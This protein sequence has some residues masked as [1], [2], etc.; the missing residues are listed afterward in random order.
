[1]MIWIHRKRRRLGIIDLR[2]REESLRLF[3]RLEF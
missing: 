2:G 1:M 3:L